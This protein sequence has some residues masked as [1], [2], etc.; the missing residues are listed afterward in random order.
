MP[1]MVTSLAFVVCQLSVVDCPFGIVLGL[2]DS[3]AV[4][5]AAVVAGVGAA[6]R[7]SSYR[8]PTS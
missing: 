1:S 5:P 2:A 6:V 8:R 3:E 7:F 4:E